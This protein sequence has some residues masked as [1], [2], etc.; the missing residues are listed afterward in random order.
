MIRTDGGGE[1][2]NGAADAYLSTHGITRQVTPAYTPQ[3]NGVAERANRTILDS[4]RCMLHRAGLSGYLW[5]EAVRTAVYIRNRSPSR[6]LDAITPY[7]AWTGTK[8]SIT[9]LRVFGCTAHVHVPA[10]R[11]ST[12]LSDRSVRCI[13]VGYSIQSKAYRL[14]NPVSG[15]ITVS[16]DVSFE[17]DR[18]VDITSPVARRHV[19]E[20]ELLPL[21]VPDVAA[22]LP[23]AGRVTEVIDLVDSEAADNDQSLEANDETGEDDQG[24]GIGEDDQAPIYHDDQADNEA[25]ADDVDHLPLSSLL[26]DP[27]PTVPTGP[28]RSNRGGGLPSSRARDAAARHQ[29]LGAM[30]VLSAAAEGVQTVEDDPVTYSQ[31]MS[32]SDSDQWEAAMEA[33]LDSIH[34]TGTWVLTDL[35]KGRQAIGSK[36]EFKIKRK[37]DGSVDRYKARLVAKGFSQKEGVDYKETFAPVAKFTSIRLLL[38]LAAQQDY[39]IHQMDVKTAW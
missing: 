13:H 3:H 37:A 4:V 19:G 39:E 28:R 5:P 10:E 2:I 23:S 18:F 11:R 21:D 24:D 25:E 26:L 6:T 12:K 17:E 9:E 38:A 20:G 1:F 32:R 30:I 36:W 31:A 35:P 34:R 33:E 14:Y 22:P 15:N 8:P 29:A 27:V 7:Q 16:R